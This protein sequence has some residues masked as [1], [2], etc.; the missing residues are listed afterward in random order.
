MATVAKATVSLENA[1]M[2]LAVIATV[3]IDTVVTIGTA[4]ILELPS[5]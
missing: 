1:A 3:A 5:L 4:V 2:A